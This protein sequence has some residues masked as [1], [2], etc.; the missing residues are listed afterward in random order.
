MKEVKQQIEAN[1]NVTLNSWFLR[2]E[3]YPFSNKINGMEN[4]LSSIE[5]IFQQDDECP[6]MVS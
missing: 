3:K 1:R 4:I 5:S 2:H 6:S